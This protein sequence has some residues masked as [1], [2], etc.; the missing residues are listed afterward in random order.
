VGDSDR[1]GF[2][3][4]G[5]PGFEDIYARAGNDL[6]AIP[7]AALAP[8]PALVAW[9]GRQRPAAGRTALVVGC[10]LGDDAEEVSRRGYRVTAFDASPTAI[11]RCRERFGQSAVGYQ[12]ADLFSL[13][14][15][16]AQAFDLVVEI[17]TLQSLPPPQRARAVAAVAA[18]AAPGG[19]VFVYCAVVGDG[20]P[21]ASRPWP[22]TP[23]EL[24]A[25]ADAGLRQAEFHDQPAGAGP[26]RYVTAV[27]ARP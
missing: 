1:A 15:G 2:P 27:Y 18:T 24:Q 9:L 26:G 20:E 11:R 3:G 4:A 22:V 7:W 19:Q 21:R 16:W 8:H 14:A 5:G 17:R 6:G 10:G 23:G 25:F 12:V 13:P